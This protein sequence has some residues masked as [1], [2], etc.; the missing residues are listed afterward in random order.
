LV[1]PK[2]TFKNVSGS[3]VNAEAEGIEQFRELA[4]QAKALFL[5]R[6]Q[7]A[8]N[9]KFVDNTV[10]VD[11]AYEGVLAADLPNGMKAGET[12]QLTGRSEFEF[13][14]HTISRITDFS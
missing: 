11:I 8:S 9:F 14:S 12:L 7:Q 1:H 2:V 5:S 6:H 13:E 10:S 4:E 3:E